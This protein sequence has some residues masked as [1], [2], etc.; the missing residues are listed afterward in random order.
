MAVFHFT[1][2]SFPAKYRLEMAR[3]YYSSVAEINIDPYGD[4]PFMAQGRF[5]LLP[6]AAVADLERSPCRVTRTRAQ[7]E[8]GNGDLALFINVSGQFWINQQGAKAVSF[9]AGHAYL[10]PSDCPG[11]SDLSRRGIDVVMPNHELLPF[12]Q[13]PDSALRKVVPDSPPLRLLTQYASWLANEQEALPPDLANLAGSHLRD[14][15]VMALGASRDGQAMAAKGGLRAARLQAIKADIA[16]NLD[17]PAAL[18]VGDLTKRQGISPR[19][20]RALF[21]DDNTCFT[22]YVLEQRLE[23]CYRQLQAPSLLHCTISRLALDNGFT[24]LSW[25]NRTFKRRFGATP[26]EVRNELGT[27]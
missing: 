7:A 17:N 25:F 1:S 27:S 13:N 12:L 26:S 23:R 6:K 19:Y 9:G 18:N 5:N 24:D 16:D 15:A 11:S 2:A 21:A 20:L 3:D 22:D 8:G 14:I 10:S 4:E